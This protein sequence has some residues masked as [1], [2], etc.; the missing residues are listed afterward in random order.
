MYLSPLQVLKYLILVTRSVV[1]YKNH[2]LVTLREHMGTSSVSWWGS[3]YSCFSFLCCVL[4]VFVLF[5][6]V[7]ELF[8]HFWLP[9]RVSLTFISVLR[10]YF[11]FYFY[12]LPITFFNVK[13]RT[14][15]VED[16]VKGCTGLNIQTTAV[17]YKGSGYNI[18]RYEK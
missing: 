3:C 11:Y 12:K 15:A 10:S 13:I 16:Y 18:L 17:L 6:I 14:Q 2:A 8:F 4:F 1:S 7:S 5:P 9:F